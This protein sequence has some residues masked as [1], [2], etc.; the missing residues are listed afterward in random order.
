MRLIA[1]TSEQMF[2]GDAR[3]IATLLDEGFYAIHLR[4][5][6]VELEQ[7]R[8]LLRAIPASYHS[9]ITLHDHFSLCGEFGVGGVHLNRRSP[10]PPCGFVGRVSTS[11]HSVEEV[12]RV[13][14]EVDY[15][16]LSPIFN[17]VSKVGYESRFAVE[18]LAEARARGVIG[19]GV[20]ALGGVTAD[21]IS[22]VG[23]LGF[24]GAA[25][26]GY[27]WSESDGEA[28]RRKARELMAIVRE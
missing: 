25:L 21:N 14:A 9:Q 12:E 19:D 20:V 3:A 11:C 27:L 26:L 13:A 1:V 8:E 23:E 24:G 28:L 4:K 17:S 5:P 10:H 22:L 7:V 18:E 2:E 6:T 16:F 15:A